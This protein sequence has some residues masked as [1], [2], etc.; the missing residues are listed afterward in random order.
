MK[1]ILTKSDYNTIKDLIVN[2]P[3]HL[4]TKE[5]SLLAKEIEKA[6]KVPEEKIDATVIRIN[7]HFEVQDVASGQLLKFQMT[8]PKYSN[9]AEKKLSILTPLGV[10]LIGCQEGMQIEY[11]LPGGLKKLKILSV[12]NHVH[13]D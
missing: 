1:P 10:A 4:I 2:T 6:K 7:S 9:L 5:I 11:V 8:L 3:S 13:A 12:K